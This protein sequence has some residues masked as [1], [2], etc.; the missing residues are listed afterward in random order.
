MIAQA[1]YGMVCGIIL[2]LGAI[3]I[4]KYTFK[5]CVGCYFSSQ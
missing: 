5:K 1:F 2:I 4:K 3:K